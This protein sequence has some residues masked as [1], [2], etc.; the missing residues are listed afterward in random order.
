MF[1]L[2]YKFAH[3]QL[4]M[5]R[6]HRSVILLILQISD[7]HVAWNSIL[8]KKCGTRCSSSLR[9]TDTGG[10]SLTSDCIKY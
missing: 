5:K 2:K 1:R 6:I 4:C 8:K 3:G 10:T 7:K 9:N